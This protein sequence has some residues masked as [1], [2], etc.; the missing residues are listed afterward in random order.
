MADLDRENES[1]KHP[2]TFPLIVKPSRWMIGLHLIGGGMLFNA[3]QAS[4]DLPDLG[5]IPTF[6]LIAV[7]FLGSKLLISAL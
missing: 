6:T 4:R 1:D 5:A 3:W 7:G 2:P